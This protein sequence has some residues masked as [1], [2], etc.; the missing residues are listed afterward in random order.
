MGFWYKPDDY[1]KI[2]T[3]ALRVGSDSSNYIQSPA[4]DPTSND[5]AFYDFLMST[6]TKVGTPVWTAVDYLA[7]VV[8]E[9]GT[10]S[11]IIDGIR[12]MENDFFRH[13]PYV[14]E[15]IALD[16]FRVSRVKPTEVMQ[17]LADTLSWYWYVDYNRYIR[18]FA[19]ST[20]PAPISLTPTSN[21]FANLS[22]EADT[23]RLINRQVV[24][25][26]DETSTTDYSQVVQGDGFVREW[27]MKT[28]F[29]NLTV[30]LNNG[31]STDT[32]EATT[33]TT[34][35]KATAHGLAVGDYIVNRT[36]SNAVREVLTVPDANTFTVAA[37]TSQA[38]GDTFSLFV[39]QTVGV[40]G[41]D[42]EASFDYMSNFTEKS[43]RASSTETTLISGEFLLFTYNEVIPILVQRTDNVS[44]ANI[45]ALLGYGDGIFDGQPITNKSIKTR[46]EAMA[47][48]DSYVNKYSNTIITARFTTEQEGLEA[49]Q[50][51]SIQ[52]TGV[53]Q[54]SINQ[55]F[56]IQSVKLR[57]LAFGEN[58]YTIVCSSLLFGMLELLQQILAS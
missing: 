18:L 28:S 1:T 34:T 46:A 36:R 51:I 13:Y 14:Q 38:S 16:D 33:S 9:T 22:V 40:E 54:R 32:M 48:A 4:I 50:I 6:A 25:A 2:T 47:L 7:I 8:T 45:K 26:S 29:A 24:R 12:I 52:D 56:V 39:A 15:G 17:R 21:N 37:V 27:L 35:V 11:I 23:T 55:S 57:Q 30:K 49:G 20:L 5:F 58:R 44:V 31:S 42:V 43:I 19:Q 53:S 41:I 10:S 3:F